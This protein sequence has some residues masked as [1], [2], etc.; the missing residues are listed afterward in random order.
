M[1]D[2]QIYDQFAALIRYPSEDYL[3]A[4][5][6]CRAALAAE[7]PEAAE[8]IGR[9]AEA[10]RGL[11]HEQRQELFVQIF[12]LNPV[13]VLEVGWHLYGDTY[14]RGTF[15]VT[16]REH[17]RRFGLPEDSELPDHLAHALAVLGRMDQDE[18]NQ[19]AAKSVLP[20]LEKMLAGLEGKTSPY[21]D[22]L[23]ALW[24]GLSR[25]HARVLE[26]VRHE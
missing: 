20:A 10:V 1:P 2:P 18:A 13:C 4:F 14:D 21:E 26:E 23:K 9:F 8:R 3:E 15:L 19:F 16:M 22:V 17:L 25:R 11:S 24:L 5:E 7:D 12:D 6:K